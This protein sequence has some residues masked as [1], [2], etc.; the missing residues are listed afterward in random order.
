MFIPVMMIPSA[1]TVGVAELEASG[2]RPFH[3]LLLQQG[4]EMA[5]VAQKWEV[6]AVERPESNL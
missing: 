1:R 5:L 2:V 4:V 3:W 6:A